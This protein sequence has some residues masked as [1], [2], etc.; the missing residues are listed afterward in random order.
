MKRSGK[1]WWRCGACA[2]E[3]NASGHYPEIC[4]KCNSLSDFSPI[5]EFGRISGWGFRPYKGNNA[6]VKESNKVLMQIVED[7][8]RRF[9]CKEEF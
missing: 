2:F 4:P 1:F 5:V 3:F 6:W 8:F 9:K 7:Y